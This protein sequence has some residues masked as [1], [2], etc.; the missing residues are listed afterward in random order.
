MW[1][2]RAVLFAVL[3]LAPA[4]AGAQAEEP[5]AE[6][7]PEPVAEATP[8][9]TPEPLDER[10]LTLVGLVRQIDNLALSRHALS[11]ALEATPDESAREPLALQVDLL[12]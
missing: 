9:P 4:S 10:M 6:A 12:D 1:V 3:L 2:R 8:E 11:A 7:T 5:V